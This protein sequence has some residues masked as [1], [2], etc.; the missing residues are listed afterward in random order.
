MDAID[1][2]EMLCFLDKLDKL[3][4]GA[5]G[6]YSLGFQTAMMYVRRYVNGQDP[7][8]FEFNGLKITADKN[9]HD[10]SLLT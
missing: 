10:L 6:D 9:P 5:G 8:L 4:K 7:Y 3:F 2:K 1:S